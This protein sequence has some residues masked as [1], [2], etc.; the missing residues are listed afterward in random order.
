MVRVFARTLVYLDAQLQQ[1]VY[2]LIIKYWSVFDECG[3][4]IPVHN[5]ECVI[6]TGNASLIAVKKIMYGPNKLLIMRKAIRALEKV[7]HIHQI[8]D[9]RWLFKAVLALKPYQECVCHITDFVWRFCVNYAPLTVVTRIIAC[10][11][12]RCNL[13]FQ[14]NLAPA[15]GCGFTM[16]LPATTSWQWQSLLP[17]RK[18]LLFR[19]LILSSELIW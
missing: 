15:N 6:D 13:L 14:K 8:T 17:V 3:I 1:T 19:G 12:P 16:L 11:I 7:G 9:G 5:Y 4:F 18:S 2:A 10:P